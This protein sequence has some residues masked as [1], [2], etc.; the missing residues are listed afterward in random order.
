M[1]IIECQTPYKLKVK[2]KMAIR[3]ITVQGEGTVRVIARRYGP[4]PVEVLDRL[5]GL[6]IEERQIL[7]TRG[8]SVYKCYHVCGP[9]E[10]IKFVSDKGVAKVIVVFE[11]L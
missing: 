6:E 4:V 11:E 2:G 9:N 3:N 7:I 5:S 1:K 8:G 10:I